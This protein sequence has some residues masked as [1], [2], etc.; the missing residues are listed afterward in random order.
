R[1]VWNQWLYHIT[2]VEEDAGIPRVAANNWQ[3]LNNSRT[4]IHAEG[5]EAVAAPD[6]TVS[7]VTVNAQSCP[8]SIGIM[9]RIGNGGSLQGERGKG[10]I[11]YNGDRGG[12][13]SW[14]GSR[15]RGRAL[16]PGEFEDVILDG[17]APVAGQIFVTANAPPVEIL[18]PSA[19]LA[20]LPH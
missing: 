13:G 16:S 6:L 18:T 5:R 12:G 1:P 10:F 2:N 14:I 4:Q 17:I 20:R 19:N 15:Q 8:A 7:K 11:F 3:T 9:A